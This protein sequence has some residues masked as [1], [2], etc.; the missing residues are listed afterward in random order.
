MQTPAYHRVH[1]AQN[2]RYMDMNYNSITL[3][4]DWIFGTLQP[5]DDA[6]PVTY[7]IT[8]GVDTASFWDVHF[9]E[10]R[11]LW[12]DMRSAPNL[13]TAILY[14]V[15]PP[16]WSPAGPQRTVAE[17]KAQLLLAAEGAVESPPGPQS[18]S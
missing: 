3:L 13:R 12:R 6:E 5:L 17:L 16:G 7:G 9:G 2:V 18:A 10:F 15:M 8:R 1:H 14:L 11:L 4:W